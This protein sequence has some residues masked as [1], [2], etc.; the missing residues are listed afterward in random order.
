MGVAHRLGHTGRA[1]AEHE[2]G[3]VVRASPARGRFGPAVLQ[4]F[5]PGIVEIGNRSPAQ[6][7]DEHGRGIAIGDCMD[8]CCQ[9]EGVPHLSVLPRRA[10]QDRCA[11]EFAHGIDHHDELHAIGHHDG[12]TVTSSDPTG[13]QVPGKGIAHAL[14]IPE[15]PLF[16]AAAQG[17]PIPESVRGPLQGHVHQIRSHWKHSSPF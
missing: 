5:D 9:L 2:D 6:E 15:R 8:R 11:A 14:E 16:V 7:D 1:G 10:D 12:H 3:L 4:G 13:G 17:M